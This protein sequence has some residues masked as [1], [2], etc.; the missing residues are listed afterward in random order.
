MKLGFLTEDKLKA[1][2]RTDFGIPE[3]KKYPMPD[4]SHVK[5]AIRMFNHVDSAHEAELAKNIKSKMKKYGISPDTVGEKNRLKKYLDESV[6]ST[7]KKI[8]TYP[9]NTGNR[10]GLAWRK[11]FKGE[12]NEEAAR[13][14]KF[15]IGGTAA[16]A[17]GGFALGGPIGAAIGALNG[18]N[19]GML[20]KDIKDSK[21][22]F[23]KKSSDQKEE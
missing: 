3:L 13:T 11:K 2:E 6:G 17:L 16:G 7:I 5:A 14:R 19:I 1:D 12:D 10:V 15:H 22:S 23:K 8:A 21:F 9:I 20:A 4:E 18:T